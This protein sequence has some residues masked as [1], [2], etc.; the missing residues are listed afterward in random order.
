MVSGLSP[1]PSEPLRARC[2]SAGLAEVFFSYSGRGRNVRCN[3]P[4]SIYGLD[5]TR[6]EKELGS[7]KIWSTAHVEDSRGA[8]RCRV[9]RLVVNKRDDAQRGTQAR[10]CRRSDAHGRCGKTG[11]MGKRVLH[12]GVLHTEE[13]DAPA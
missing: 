13:G 7:S 10:A 12:L 8:R 11:G 1:V 5:A 9:N 2:G 6:D 3:R 4:Y